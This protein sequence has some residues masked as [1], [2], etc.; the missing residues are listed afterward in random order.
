MLELN[1]WHSSYSIGNWVLDNQH[2]LLLLLCDEAVHQVPDDNVH[3][4]PGPRFR[5]ARDE[6]LACLDDHFRT[7]ERLLERCSVLVYEPHHAEHVHFLRMLD[8]RLQEVANGEIGR[9]VFR[10]FLVAWWS[11]HILHADR[12]IAPLI[13][14][15][16]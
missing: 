14:R 12:A 3:E 7:E 2:R 6:L 11:Q 16:R 9:G 8:A 10:Q 15:L 13:Q 4:S 1:R 5:P